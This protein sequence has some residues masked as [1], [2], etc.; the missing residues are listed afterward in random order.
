MAT[1][2]NCYSNEK[3]IKD[4]V[5]SCWFYLSSDQPSEILDLARQ[6][7]VELAKFDSLFVWLVLSEL[8]QAKYF[9]PED[10]SSTGSHTSLPMLDLT[11]T[12]GSTWV[13]IHHARA[14]MASA[15]VEYKGVIPSSKLEELT[16]DQIPWSAIAKVMPQAQAVLR[17][18]SGM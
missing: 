18:I 6:L 3:D 1:Y 17:E 9:P 12:N 8:S 16:H 5:L 11:S 13:Q 2:V 7:Y 14:M 4:L 15:E 10:M